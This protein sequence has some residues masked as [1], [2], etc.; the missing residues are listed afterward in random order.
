[1]V[2]SVYRNVNRYIIDP[3]S[4]IIANQFMNFTE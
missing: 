4:M 3:V 1:M 2:V